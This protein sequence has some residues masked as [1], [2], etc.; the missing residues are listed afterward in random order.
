MS[1]RS[2]P[3]PF[4]IDGD[5]DATE[6]LRAWIAHGELHVSLLLGMWADAEDSQIDE[7]EAWGQLL[8]DLARHVANGMAQSH[9][10]AVEDT[11]ARIRRAFEEN[12]RYHTQRIEGFFPD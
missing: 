6:M 4:E 7:C 5:P 3:T 12:S 9:G 8:A 2:L 1:I 11:F 10:W